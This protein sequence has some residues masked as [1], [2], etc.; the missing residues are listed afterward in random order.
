MSM[1]DPLL[2]QTAQSPEAV[3]AVA[4]LRRDDFDR[5]VWCL[6]G[7]AVDAA[8]IN[9]AIAEIDDSVRTRR[10]L[11]FVTPNVNFLVRAMK[12]ESARRD[13]LNADLSLADGAPL[14]AMAKMLGV[15]VPSRV[16]GSDLFEALRRRPGFSGRRLKVFF[17]GGRPGAAE[18][19]FDAIN[20]E[21]GGV[22]AVG[23]HNPGFGD[24]ESMSSDEVI[25][26]INSTEPDFVMVALG[27]A[28]GQAWI[29]YNRDR[30]T[31]PVTAHLGAVV[32][33]TAG[34]VARAPEW[35]QRAGLE[36]VW[37][38]KEEPS[39]W[40][41]YFDDGVA[42]AWLALTGL[43]PQSRQAGAV[44]G[45]AQADVTQGA[46]ETIVRI[47]GKPGHNSLKPVREAFRS[48]AAR[49][50]PVCLDLAGVEAADR[51]FLGQVLMLEKH[52]ARAG[53]SIT[54]SG[55]NRRLKALFRANRMNYAPAG[56]SQ[57]AARDETGLRKAAF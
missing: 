48:A 5:D 36:W 25:T 53:A 55:A 3:G 47:T 15:P 52:L 38:I 26:K 23:W 32:D 24:V 11:S 6:M 10:Q 34:G 40:R 2:N 8:D 27:A 21:K 44:A 12:D 28:K 35:V 43:L 20:R 31:A 39:L 18:A 14:V 42:L 33:F 41:R 19:A 1:S 9:R 49:G 7:L 54:L 50:R 56:A 16:A 29:E 17:F 57:S 4:P 30:L 51:A 46:G 13:I 22:E 37:R 45:D